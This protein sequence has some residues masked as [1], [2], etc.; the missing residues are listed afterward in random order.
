MNNDSNVNTNDRKSV[1]LLQQ[2][3]RMRQCERAEFG[4]ASQDAPSVPLVFCSVGSLLDIERCHYTRGGGK[5]LYIPLD[6]LRN[7]GLD[8]GINI[9]PG[10]RGM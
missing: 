1:C 8:P 7:V 5:S 9:P 2:Q 10:K 3:L 4:F 6:H